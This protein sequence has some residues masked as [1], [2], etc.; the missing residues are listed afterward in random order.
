MVPDILHG[1]EDHQSPE[2]PP[3]GVD[4][5]GIGLRRHAVLSIS[6]RIIMHF[7]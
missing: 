1:D 4:D 3:G 2:Q 7:Q 5:A 6:Q